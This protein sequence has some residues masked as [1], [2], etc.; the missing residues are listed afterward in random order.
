MERRGLETTRRASASPSPCR[1][2]HARPPRGWPRRAARPLCELSREAS[3]RRASARALEG[4]AADAGAPGGDAA[5]ANE[6][7]DGGPDDL[8][9]QQ[10]GA[11]PL[12]VCRGH[13]APFPRG[14]L[15]SPRTAPRRSARRAA[16]SPFAKCRRRPWSTA[17]SRRAGGPPLIHNLLAVAGVPLRRTSAR[18][19][20]AHVERHRLGGRA[21]SAM[22]RVARLRRTSGP[23][24]DGRRGLIEA[25]SSGN[26]VSWPHRSQSLPRGSS[27]AACHACGGPTAKLYPGTSL[28]KEARLKAVH[29]SA[30]SILTAGLR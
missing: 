21:R 26:R 14:A 23:G 5:A 18:S 29:E 11:L 30:R 9:A 6:A 12:R 28:K 1:T 27:W 10:C 3:S 15:A 25:L 24:T 13:V 4:G 22:R 16:R 19:G 8:G 17:A 20:R 7:R 2:R